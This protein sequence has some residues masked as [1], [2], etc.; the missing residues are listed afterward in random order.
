MGQLSDIRSDLTS[1][2][3]YAPGRSTHVSRRS[4]LTQPAD[5]RKACFTGL[6][7]GLFTLKWVAVG[8]FSC[9]LRLLPD[10]RQSRTEICR[11]MLSDFFSA[12][13]PNLLEVF[14]H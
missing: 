10:P 4:E 1:D 9:I 12:H 14:L 7:G 13:S 3:P 5:L 11:K 2:A 6:C 8:L